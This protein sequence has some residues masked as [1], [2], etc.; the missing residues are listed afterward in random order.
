[1]R[2]VRYVSSLRGRAVAARQAHNLE[3]V[4]SN[5]TPATF[6]DSKHLKGCYFLSR[7]RD[8]P[9]NPEVF[10]LTGIFVNGIIFLIYCDSLKYQRASDS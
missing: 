4:G 2:V 1:M 6:F 3:V 10:S 7:V 8:G 5:P 9:Y